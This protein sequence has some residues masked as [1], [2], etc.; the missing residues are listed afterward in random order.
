MAPVSVASTKATSWVAPESDA[1]AAPEPNERATTAACS[2]SGNS[3]ERR[4][5]LAGLDPK[6]SKLDLLVLSTQEQQPPVR[7]PCHPVPGAIPALGRPRTGVRDEALLGE[8]GAPPVALRHRRSRDPG[9]SRN[10]GGHRASEG[11]EHI[12]PH[13]GYRSADGNRTRRV[14]L[15]DLMNRGPHGRLGRS[16]LV[17]ETHVRKSPKVLLHQLRRA[18]LAG[19]DRGFEPLQRSPPAASIWA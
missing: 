2:I 9:L 5:D 19:D 12:D 16:V 11:V 3:S 6:A 1:V 17:V 18:A 7:R 10:A 8:L 15:R 13:A 4:L 14:V